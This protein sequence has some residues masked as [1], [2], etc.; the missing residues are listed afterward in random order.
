MKTE[1]Q[2]PFRRSPSAHLVMFGVLQALFPS[3][4]FF[5]FPVPVGD[6]LYISRR[7]RS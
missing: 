4:L 6:L 7:V 2:C 3:A 1:S 5:Q